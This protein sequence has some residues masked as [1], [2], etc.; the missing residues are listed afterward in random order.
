MTKIKIERATIESTKLGLNSEGTKINVSISMHIGS[1]LITYTESYADYH[2]VTFL[3]G[4]LT[5]SE[6]KYWEYLN[7]KGNPLKPQ[8]YVCYNDA[9]NLVAFGNLE[10]NKWLVF[11]RSSHSCF[12]HNGS[13]IE[14]AVT[15][16]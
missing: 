1:K 7:N 11:A 16:I 14:N 2:F 4:I 6:K 9:N 13:D 5:I 3:N 12:I 10:Q 15:C 8:V